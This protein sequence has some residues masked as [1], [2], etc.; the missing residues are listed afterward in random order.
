MSRQP[1]FSTAPRPRRAHRWDQAA[2]VAGLAALAL[3]GTAAWR[4]REEARDAG[5]RLAEVRREVETASGKLRTLAGQAR[6]GAPV[7]PAAEAPPARIVAA[8]ASL[9]PGHARLD[10]LSIDYERGG[11]LQLNVVAGD[12]GAWD[13]FLDR[14]GR[15][16]HFREVEPGPE[17]RDAEV[18]SLVRALWVGSAP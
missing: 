15:E 8:V 4:A 11:V 13:L 10:G 17:S 5:V 16:P 18:R 7:L 3:S 9:L 14:L 12:A 2:L 6:V 1:D